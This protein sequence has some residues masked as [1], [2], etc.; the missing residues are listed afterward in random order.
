MHRKLLDCL[1]T[2]DLSRIGLPNGR[3][4]LLK[5]PLLNIQIIGD[6][7]IQQIGPVSITSFRERIKRVD[8]VQ[9]K[10]KTDSLLFHMIR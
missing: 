9:F 4:N 1:M 5:L 8:F 3:A 7:F 2:Q 10:P 6:R